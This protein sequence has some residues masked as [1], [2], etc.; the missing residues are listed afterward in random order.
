MNSLLIRRLCA[1]HIITATLSLQ[2]TSNIVQSNN[3][4]GRFHSASIVF[5]H[6]RIYYLLLR[7]AIAQFPHVSLTFVPK[8]PKSHELYVEEDSDVYQTLLSQVISGKP[9]LSQ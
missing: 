2:L 9:T 8:F 3:G 1:F 7:V 5:D 4:R 6:F